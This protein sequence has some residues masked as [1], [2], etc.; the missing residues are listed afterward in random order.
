MPNVFRFLTC[1]ITGNTFLSGPSACALQLLALL[2]DTPTVT[3]AAVTLFG[4]V[5]PILR[6]LR[7]ESPQ[8][9]GLGSLDLLMAR[10][11][12]RCK[13]QCHISRH[14]QL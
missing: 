8:Q 14:G 12:R 13:L 3:R 11:L 7:D 1:S 5:V 10:T 4:L 2:G 9:I 6:T